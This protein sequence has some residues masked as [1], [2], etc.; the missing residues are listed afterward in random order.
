V[1]LESGPYD[2]VDSMRDCPRNGM[3][4]SDVNRYGRRNERCDEWVG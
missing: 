1:N 2:R 4:E 3:E